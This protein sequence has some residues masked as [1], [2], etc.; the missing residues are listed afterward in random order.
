[1]DREIFISIV[2]PVYNVENYLDECIKSILDQSYR[3]FELVLIDDGSFDSSGNICDFYSEQDSRINVIHKENGGLSDARNTG[4]ERSKGEFIT[5]ID[6]DDVIS[7]KYLEV[8]AGAIQKG[9]G[10]IVQGEMTQ[11]EFELGKSYLNDS[12]EMSGVEAFKQCASWK[13]IKVYACAKLYKKELFQKIRFPV[14]RLNEDSCVF[15]KILCSAEKVILIPD[16]IYFYRNTPGSIMNRPISHERFQVMRVPQ[17]M[18]D[19]FGDK[20]KMFEEEIEYYSMRLGI[21][22]YNESLTNGVIGE[23]EEDQ[24]KVLI[25]LKR[26]NLRN[27]Y[28]DMKY[29]LLLMLIRISPDFY[30]ILLLYRKYRIVQKEDR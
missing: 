16:I 6:S 24:K 15:Y 1:M 20:Q 14:G 8:L 2:V 26:F 10:D 22:L 4:I 12:I 19:Y 23:V 25:S 7:K 30:K 21:N 9:E 18:R 28:L 13:K 5:F 29:R 17:E 11:N 3:N 27:K